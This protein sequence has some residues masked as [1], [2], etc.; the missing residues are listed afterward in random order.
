MLEL[1]SGWLLQCGQVECGRPALRMAYCQSQ[2]TTLG[3][4]RSHLFLTNQ[5]HFVLL[6]Q[7]LSQQFILT[8]FVYVLTI[9]FCGWSVYLFVQPPRT[10]TTTN[11]QSSKGDRSP[12]FISNGKGPVM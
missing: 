6:K 11:T 12:N 10:A 2:P 3:L 5:V 1:N 9:G 8:I 4:E 7:A